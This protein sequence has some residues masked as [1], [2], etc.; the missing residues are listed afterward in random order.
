[1][2]ITNVPMILSGTTTVEMMQ[3]Q[4]M[5]MQENELLQKFYSWW[6]FRWACFGSN[7]HHG[8]FFLFLKIYH[9]VEFHAVL[10]WL[11]SSQPTVQRGKHCD[12]G[13]RNGVSYRLKVISGGRG[14]NT[15][16]GWMLWVIRGW[17]GFV[18]DLSSRFLLLFFWA[19]LFLVFLHLIR[20]L[21][22]IFPCLR[23]PQDS[24]S[25]PEAWACALSGLVLPVYGCDPFG[26]KPKLRPP[27]RGLCGCALVLFCLFVMLGGWTLL[28]LGCV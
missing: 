10:F 23:N 9:L 28:H 26:Q 13:T 12:N 6:Q 15:Q 20:N 18:S 22:A 16:S 17:D 27:I 7:F 3:R 4:G 24:S 8:N 1:M 11:Y 21:D 25:S 2:M 14:I 5:K 19:F